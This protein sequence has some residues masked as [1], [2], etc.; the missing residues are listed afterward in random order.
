M[1]PHRQIKSINER[2]KLK[3]ENPTH[4][5]NKGDF[6]KYT[7]KDPSNIPSSSTIIALG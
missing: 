1:T 2:Q 4:N 7:K 3:M 6:F 5:I